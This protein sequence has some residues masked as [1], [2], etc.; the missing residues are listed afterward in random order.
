M[1]CYLGKLA[2]L[3]ISLWLRKQV[4]LL[5]LDVSSPKDRISFF[6]LFFISIYIKFIFPSLALSTGPHAMGAP[7][8]L[9][10]EWV[11]K[12]SLNSQVTI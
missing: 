9:M 2:I 10:A 6:F 4:K 5:L 12:R 3:Y 1:F 8:G 11:N 7:R